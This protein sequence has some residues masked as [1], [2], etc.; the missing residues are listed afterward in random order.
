MSIDDTE[1]CT[2]RILWP[3]TMRTKI[4]QLDLQQQKLF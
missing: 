4:M 1:L 3:Q 2:S